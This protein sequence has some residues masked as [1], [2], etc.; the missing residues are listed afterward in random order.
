MTPPTQRARALDLARRRG[1]LTSRDAAGL[2]IHRQVLTRLVR[3][4]ELERIAR[5]RYR[6]PEAPVTEHHGL[7]LAAAAIPEGVVCLVSALAFHGIGTQMPNQVWIALDRRARK[8]SLAWPPVRVVRFGGRA[9]TEG[10]E[11]HRL[12]GVPVRVYEVAKT[13][14]DVFKYRN[15]VGLDVAL[16]ALKEAWGE[17]R[18]DMDRLTRFAKICRVDKVMRPYLEAIIS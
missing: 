8:P 12:E 17:G 13:L 3:G 2:G 6:L 5:G 10:V 18:V 4:G 15:K 11:T 1:V 16:E 7:A 9:L 14:A